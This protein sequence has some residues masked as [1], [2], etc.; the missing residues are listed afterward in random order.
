MNCLEPVALPE[1]GIYLTEP[2]AHRHVKGW[3]FRRRRGSARDRIEGD[4]GVMTLDAA[5]GKLTEEVRSKQVRQV[6]KPVVATLADQ[7]SANEY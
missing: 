5:I 2:L 7:G 1:N 3:S 6:A 4:L